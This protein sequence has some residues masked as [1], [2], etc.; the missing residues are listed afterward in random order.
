[1]PQ[2]EQEKNRSNLVKL[3]ALTLDL[4]GRLDSIAARGGLDRR[5]RNPGNPFIFGHIIRLQGL[6]QLNA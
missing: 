1:M 3:N 2:L 5:N 4:T 6:A